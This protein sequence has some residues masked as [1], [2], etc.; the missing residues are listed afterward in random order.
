MSELD[1]CCYRLQIKYWNNL[2]LPRRLLIVLHL[3]PDRQ[4][5]QLWYRLRLKLL[6]QTTRQIL[7]RLDNGVVPNHFC[8][9]VGGDTHYVALR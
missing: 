3:T 5:P 1:A 2:H 8:G 4:L 9:S 6:A 7:A